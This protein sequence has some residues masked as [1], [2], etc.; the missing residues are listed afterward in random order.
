MSRK[1]FIATG[2]G[3]WRL[4]NQ[5]NVTAGLMAATNYYAAGAAVN[6]TFTSSASGSVRQIVS[7][8]KDRGL[9]GAQMSASLNS[10]VT[11]TV[12]ASLG[13]T[14]QTSGFRELGDVLS[15]KRLDGDWRGA[16]FNA[17]YR[18]QYTASLGW[19]NDTFGG[20]QGSYSRA[21]T[22]DGCQ[23]QYFTASWSKSI[24][25]ATVSLNLQHAS[26]GRYSSG[27]TVLLSVSI[28]FGPGSIRSYVNHND[29]RSRLGASA[30]EQVN[31]AV[32]YGLSVEHDRA[33]RDTSVSG[34]LN[35]LPRYFQA[36]LSAARN[37]ASSTMY[38]GLVRGGVAIHGSGVTLSPY[39]INDTFAIAKVG[40]MAGVQITTPQGPVW[41]DMAGQ[42]VVPALTPYRASRVQVT[43]T[44]L[45]RN[46]DLVNAYREIEAGR[47]AVQHLDFGV[48]KT[49][50]VLLRTTVSDGSALARGTSVVD[51]DG[52][53]VTTVLNQGKVFL[54]GVDAPAPLRAEMADGRRCELLF[55]LG[56]KP[57]VDSY[58]ETVDAVCRLPN[59]G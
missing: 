34:S 39:Q 1:P 54:P 31:E 47:G 57:D 44:S 25:R 55:Q 23:T 18:L 59:Q 40:D 32:G 14:M 26:G 3:T 43:T 36:S 33:E 46:V 21:S 10:Q 58:Y 53:F 11:E 6:R 12:S 30:S 8:A 20:V 13:A 27:D 48:L 56:D 16:D 45:P 5:S 50:R 49:R 42:A 9:K 51:A 22:F 7:Y 37:G 4:G 41:T 17:R 35:L 24:K 28:P 52:A 19:S 29:G 2:T 15:D 38:S